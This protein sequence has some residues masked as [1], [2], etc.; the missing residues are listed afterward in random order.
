MKNKQ[1]VFVKVDT[2]EKCIE[3]Y[4]ILTR[5]GEGI[6]FLSHNLIEGDP[7]AGGDTLH[8]NGEKKWWIRTLLG[9]GYADHKTEISLTELEQFLQK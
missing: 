9:T 2:P 5:A 3:A 1:E 8:F 7:L 4:G 6:F